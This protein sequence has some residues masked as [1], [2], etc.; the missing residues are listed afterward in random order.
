MFVSRTGFQYRKIISSSLCF[1]P[2]F[3]SFAAM[4]LPDDIVIERDEMLNFMKKCVVTAGA[5]ESHALQLAEVLVD[6]DARGHYSHGLNRLDMYVRDLQ[7]KT[8][9]CSGEPT[10]LN[11]K[12]ATAWV[13]GNNLLGPVVGNYSMDLAI[14]KAKEVGVGW[15]VAKGSN[16]FGIAGHYSIRAMK[17]GLL[18]LAFTNTSPVC[19]PTRAAK[20]A[21]GTNPLSLAAAATNGDSYV[22]DMATT[23][24]AVG[25]RA[26]SY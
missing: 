3:R 23:T 9:A 7:Q 17:E 11:D 20:A 25:K 12:A 24:V 22:L 1:R 15:V 6:G 8:T 26:E 19:Y 13:N 4:V 2:Q 10:V 16:H 21:L 14:R 5:E 18:G